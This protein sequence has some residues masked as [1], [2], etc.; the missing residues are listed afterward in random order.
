MRKIVLAGFRGTGKTSVG[1]ILAER[2]GVSFFDADALIERRAGMTIPEIFRRRGEA[3]F[4]DLERGVIA[5]LRD[6][7]GVIS[8][9]GGA[10]CNPENVADLRWRGTVILLTAPPDVI[11]DRITG[12]DRPELTDLP[13]AEEVRALLERRKEAYLGAA[14]ACIDT[15]RRT[16]EEIADLILQDDT[17][18]SAAMH[19]RDVL[20]ERFGLSELKSMVA[21]DPE[22]RVCGIAG[23]PCAHSRSPL[24]YNRLFAH[25]GMRYHYTSIE[26]PDVGEI[27]RLASLLPTKGLSVTIPFKTDVMRH[28]D[29]VDDHA[30]AIGAVNTVVRCGDRLYGYNTDWIGVRTP[31]AHRRGERAVV[32]GA[33]GAAAAAAYALMSLDMDV[34]ILARRPDAARRLAERFRC[35]WGALKDFRES[36]A[37][38]VVDATP[39]GMD[40]DTRALLGPDDLEPGMTIFDL[41]YTPPE[42]PLIRAAKRAGCEV[43]PGTEM[44]IHQAVAQ[45]QLMTGIAVTPALIRGMLQ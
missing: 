36:G 35:R 23:N 22:L 16:P 30:A 9:G 31:L 27:V 7:N 8:T 17:I 38:V 19:E 15:G 39:V 32:L 41:V 21:H 2:L 3:G 10:V 40:P 6:A 42:T 34:S 26:W 33:G 29:E 44:F 12:S 28:V 25:F 1:Q 45:F 37:D 13:P 43:I 5:S 4:R 20:L 14:D 24:I 18:S 11:R